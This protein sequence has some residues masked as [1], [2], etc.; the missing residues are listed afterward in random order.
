MSRDYLRLVNYGLYTTVCRE[1]ICLKE[2]H[3]AVSLI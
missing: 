1:G 3:I 2:K